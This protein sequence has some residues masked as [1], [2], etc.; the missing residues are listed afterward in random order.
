MCKHAEQIL[1]RLMCCLTAYESLLELHQR[2]LVLIGGCAKQ[3]CLIVMSCCY[4]LMW[5]SDGVKGAIFVSV[6]WIDADI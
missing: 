1:S 5:L 2:G 3:N 4:E 6:L